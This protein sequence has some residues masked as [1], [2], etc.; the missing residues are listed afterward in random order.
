MWQ[1]I[2]SD[3]CSRPQLR[4]G[5]P[6]LVAS[7]SP[8]A[9]WLGMVREASMSSR[10]TRPATAASTTLAICGNR[11]S[12]CRVLGRFKIYIVD[13]A[14]MVTTTGFNAL[15]KLVEEPP[16][17]VKFVFATTEPDKVISTI[18]ARIT[19]LSAWCATA[20]DRIPGQLCR[21]RHRE[22]GARRAAVGGTR[23][24]RVRARLALGAG[25]A[26]RRCR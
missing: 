4:E 24:R 23:R 10:S 26:T 12:S 19:T 9:T 6:G 13:E 15:L 2:S 14:H 1:A 3:P 18:R 16:P 21:R 8:A 25:P 11:R 17:H 7:A 22:C 5:S 20:P